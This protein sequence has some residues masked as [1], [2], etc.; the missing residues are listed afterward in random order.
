MFFRV[1]NLCGC[2]SISQRDRCLENIVT[3]NDHCFSRL[4]TNSFPVLSILEVSHSLSPVQ[5]SFR[6]ILTL[7]HSLC[8]NT[9]GAVFV[10]FWGLC[11]AA[12]R[13]LDLV[14][15]WENGF[16]SV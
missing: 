2:I 1:R 7:R 15:G 13:V 9:L 6:I 16:V 11:M 4:S 5:I 14:G 8:S 12:W 3:Y 10:G